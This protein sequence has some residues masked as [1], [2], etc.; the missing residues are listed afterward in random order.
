METVNKHIELIDVNHD[1]IQSSFTKIKEYAAIKGYVIKGDVKLPTNLIG[2]NK[3]LSFDSGRQK[4]T[5]RNYINRLHKQV[6]MPTANKFLHFLFKKIYKLDS[7]PSVEYSEKE[8]K[9]QSARKLWK[10]A[11]VESEKLRI[12]YKK[13]KGDFYINYS[14]YR[15]IDF[16]KEK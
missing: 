2:M 10:K 9:I 3:A 8:L 11:F 15:D 4:K 12:E 13:E 14:K 16:Y 6:N 7:V 5:V 1:T